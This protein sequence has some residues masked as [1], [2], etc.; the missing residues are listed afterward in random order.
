MKKQLQPDADTGAGG[1][2]IAPLKK[3]SRTRI[4]PNKD[5]D[6]STLAT[7]A[8]AKWLATPSLTLLWTT[9]QAMVQLAENY[10]TELGKRI[11]VGGSRTSLTAVLKSEA[12]KIDKAVS[13]VKSYLIKKYETEAAAVPYYSKFGMVKTGNS[14]KLPRDNDK[15]KL[16]LP[17]LKAAIIEEGFAAEK[18][19]TAFWD[20]TITSYNNALAATTSTV[21]TIS[22]G[23]SAK[24]ELRL[25]LEKH[26]NAIINL[27]K[28]NYPDTWQAELRAWG[29][30]KVNY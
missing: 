9:P 20:A 10:S 12:D 1:A 5:A 30:L 17:I 19:G 22:S 2:P 14:W 23:V 15:R 6:T 8:A 11:N 29:F 4:L 27:L 26:L 7:A 18:Y 28:A 21:K 16:A 13:V 24:D 3:V 25:Q